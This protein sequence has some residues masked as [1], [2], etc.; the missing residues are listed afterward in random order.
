MMA[1]CA[2]LPEVIVIARAYYMSKY[3]SCKRENTVKTP[4]VSRFQ[5]ADVT[6]QKLNPGR[7]AN[8]GP[9][10]LAQQKSNEL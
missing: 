3:R 9:R 7:P 10:R 5:R 1:P 4:V 2:G 6:E 8:A